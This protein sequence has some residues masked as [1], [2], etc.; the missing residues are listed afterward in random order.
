MLIN[1]RTGVI[2][3]TQVEVAD[4][5]ASRRKGLLGRD[6]L[7]PSAAIVLSPCFAVHTAFMRFPIDVLFVN[8]NGVVVRVA[9]D[10]GAWRMTA[11]WRAHAV[12]EA[13]AGTATRQ[14]VRVGDRL[15][16]A[17][18]STHGRAVS[19]PVPA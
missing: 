11:S 9:R 4:T 15:Y 13:A 1:E 7:D 19:W 16:V 14:D 17:S 2:V 6:S 3:A 12:I 8:R 18:E 5:R 10:V